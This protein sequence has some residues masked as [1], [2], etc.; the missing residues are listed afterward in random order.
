MRGAKVNFRKPY[1]RSLPAVDRL[2][3][4]EPLI[5]IAGTVPRKLILEA[6]QETIDI[7]RERILAATSAGELQMIKI[8]PATLAREASIKAE[9]RLLFS[10]RSVINATGTVIHTNLGRS[11]LPDSAVKAVSD[12][13]ANYCN[14]ELSLDTGKRDSRLSH[15]EKLL[16]ELTGAEAAMVVNNNAAAVFLVLNTLANKGQVIVSRGQLVEIGGSFRIPDVMSAGGAVLVE[17]GTTNKC[18]LNDYAEAINDDSALLLKV[19]T[20]NYRILGFTEEVGR[21][22][23]VNLGRHSGLPVVEDLGSG[24]LLDLTPYGLPPEPRVQDCLKEGVPLVT[25]S[26]DKL[27]GGPQAGII[28]GEKGLIKRC[29]NNQLL[30]A[31]RVDKYTIAALE[32]TLRIYRDKEKAI[33]E[34]PVLDMLT[35]EPKDLKRQAQLLLRRLKKHINNGQMKLVEGKSAVGGGAFPLAELPSFLVSFKPEGVSLAELV[36][37]L[38]L[39]DTPVVA[40]VQQDCLLL[41]VRTLLPGQDKLVVAALKKAIE[42]L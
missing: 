23:L 34:I 21:E 36:R 16:C 33:R 26:G 1:L 7:Y 38:R 41:D 2:L 22:E 30:R 40:R 14:L 4:E 35:K 6:A 10:L 17:V 3:Q 12:T 13:S 24:T 18:Y 5:N 9:S 42:D 31:L 28:V 20:S 37:E 32:A 8:E 15:V 19:H 27:L 39:A 25:F 29:R 11:P